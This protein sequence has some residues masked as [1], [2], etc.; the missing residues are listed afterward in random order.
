[1]E[2]MFEVCN[3]LPSLK[4]FHVLDMCILPL[5]AFAYHKALRHP[6]CEREDVYLGCM[7][8]FLF[9][10]EVNRVQQVAKKV[11]VHVFLFFVWL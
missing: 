6:H 4:I 9:W 2:S 8:N 3:F 10:C 5:I 1:M 7:C 11:P